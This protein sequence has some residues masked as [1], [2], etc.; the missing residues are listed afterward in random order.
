MLAMGLTVKEIAR[1]PLMPASTTILRWAHNPSHPFSDQYVRAR[2]IGYHQMFDDMV[3]IADNSRNDWMRRELAAGISGSV[4]NDEHLQ[5]TKL[6][7]E[8][9]WKILARALPK[10]YGDKVALEHAGKDGGPIQTETSERPQA[11]GSDHLEDISKRYAGKVPPAA[12]SSKGSV[13]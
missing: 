7:L 12:P 13:H 11:T 2:E 9:R 3:E 4:L 1:R 8:T 5:R 6:R 10:I